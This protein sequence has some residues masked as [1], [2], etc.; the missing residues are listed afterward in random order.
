MD[1][2]EFYQVA[3][4]IVLASPAPGPAWCR[5]AIGRAYFGALNVAVKSLGRIGADCGHGPQKH[6]RAVAFLFASGDE[7]I[8]TASAML[9]YLKTR[10]NHADYQLERTDVETLREAR[11]AV[12]RAKDVISCL[13]AFDADP[14]RHVPVIRNIEIYIERIGKH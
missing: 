4:K 6:G 11:N 1:P 9:D 12:E 10:R 7:S 14:Q 13:D 3:Q 8:K 2:R 5:T